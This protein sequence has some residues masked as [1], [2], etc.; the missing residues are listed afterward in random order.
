M[1]FA[2]VLALGGAAAGCANKG[3]AASDATKPGDKGGPGAGPG[4]PGGKRGA[5]EFPVELV[6]V[7]AREVQYTLDAIGSVDAYERV[8]VTARVSGVVERVAFAEGQQVKAGQLL[9]EIEPKRYQVAVRAAEA[10]AARA[11]ASKADAEAGMGRRE[12]ALAKSPGLIPAEELEGWRTKQRLAEAE[13]LSAQAAYDQ[14]AL[15]LRDARVRAP[16]TG[17]IETRNVQTGQYAQP[18][19]V[20]ATLVRRDPLL[21]RFSVAEADASKLQRGQSVSFRVRGIEQGFTAKV[22]HIAGLADP[23][24]RMVP[25]T[26]EVAV[27]ERDQL[28]PGAFAEVQIPIGGGGT[29][30]VVPEAAVRPSERGFLAYVVEG[31]V[32]HERVLSLGMHTTDGQVEVRAGLKVGEKLVLRGGEAL[33]DGAKI[34]IAK[35]AAAS[36]PASATPEL[37]P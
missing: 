32:A 26:A 22:T 23:A 30:P 19:A 27:T 4:G 36:K 6:E 15:N 3:A 14:A 21:L 34:K 9:A 37:K 7:T 11:R 10:S 16:V 1:M 2:L 33:K 13:L 17:T 12:Q 29:S 35:P 5:L 18:G 25:T 8:Q 28:R 24:S 31:N 20:L